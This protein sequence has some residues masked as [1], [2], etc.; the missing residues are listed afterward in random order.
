[1]S[2]SGG[3]R[4]K[5]PASGWTTF[6]G[7]RNRQR[8][9][10]PGAGATTR[11]HRPRHGWRIPPRRRYQPGH[12]PHQGE[13][14]AGALW[15]VAGRGSEIKRS[16]KAGAGRS[17]GAPSPWSRT[18]TAACSPRRQRLISMARRRAK[19]D[20]VV[21]QVEY[22]L[23]QKKG[24]ARTASRSGARSGRPA[25]R[26]QGQGPGGDAAFDEGREVHRGGACGAW[27]LL[28]RASM[29]MRSMMACRRLVCSPMLAAKRRRSAAG[30]CSSR[31]FG[32][33]FGAE[34]GFSSRGPGSARSSRRIVYPPGARASR[35]RPSPGRKTGGP[36]WWAGGC[37]PR[38]R[39]GRRRAGD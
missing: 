31:I 11:R 6:E 30:G 23:L 8:G 36:R 14:Q 9:G 26:L 34:R 27:Q 24:V 39:P 5:L 10:P 35:P 15:P 22:R 37:G 25:A 32:G 12:F 18:A 3:G 1:M 13:A 7:R 28:D 19:V 2:S 20:G 33:P 16:K 21:H 38:Q 4:A 29:S 17:P